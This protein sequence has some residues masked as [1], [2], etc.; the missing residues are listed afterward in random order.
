[1]KKFCSKCGNQLDLGKRACAVCQAFNPY[2]ISGFSNTPIPVAT[3]TH[4][5]ITHQQ[6]TVVEQID[7]IVKTKENIAENEILRLKQTTL[8]QNEL[9][10]K[11]ELLKVKEE[12][13]QYKK[14]TLD[15]VKGVQ[16]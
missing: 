7:E 14:E 8:E 15:L 3:P 9:T 12:T 16:K 6:P 1:M 5:T 4:K 2:F 13:E 10:L 11:N